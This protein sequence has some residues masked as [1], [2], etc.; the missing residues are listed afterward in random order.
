MSEFTPS[1]RIKK[2]FEE[3]GMSYTEFEKKTGISKSALQR[4]ASGATKKIPIDAIEKIALALGVTA[5]YLMG[6]DKAQ[7]ESDS[8]IEV[9]DEEGGV[10]VL[11]NDT[12]EY[13]D[14]LR[15]RPEMK[16]LFS[17]SKKATKEDIIKAVRIIEALRDE[18]EQEM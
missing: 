3:T 13:I 7:P 1:Q 8:A 12:L 10:I 6:W 14:S 11:D 15:K 2:A 5:S 4:Y 9:R 16:M 18:S 17:V